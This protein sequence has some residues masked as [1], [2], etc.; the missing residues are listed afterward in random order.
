MPDP[1][2]S[3]SEKITDYWTLPKT[4]PNVTI[5]TSA[6]TWTALLYLIIL[7]IA[8]YGAVQNGVDI[9][10]SHLRY[11]VLGG[12]LVLI[13]PAYRI[14]SVI[15]RFLRRQGVTVT[16]LPGRRASKRPAKPNS[17]DARMA[18]RRARVEKAKAEGKL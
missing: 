1:E 15:S 11:R 10:A 8:A 3:T 18:E 9:T 17:V 5:L 13:Y 14:G 12:L 4:G 16:L 7:V 2:T 6:W